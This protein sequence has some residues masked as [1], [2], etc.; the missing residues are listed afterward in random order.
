MTANTLEQYADTV[1]GEI[2]PQSFLDK[3]FLKRY[4]KKR[5]DLAESLLKK[6]GNV[7][8]TYHKIAVQGFQIQFNNK[9]MDAKGH[10]VKKLNYTELYKLSEDVKFKP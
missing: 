10:R 9:C 6:F 3:I 1:A 5:A 7:A 4:Q 8:E 2:L